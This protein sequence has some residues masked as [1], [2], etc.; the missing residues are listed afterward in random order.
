VKDLVPS[1]STTP[2]SREPTAESASPSPDSPSRFTHSGL[3]AAV[4]PDSPPLIPDSP[5]P[6]P[7]PCKIS[8]CHP[9]RGDLEQTDSRVKD[10]GEPSA[11][12]AALPARDPSAEASILVRKRPRRSRTLRTSSISLEDCPDI[13]NARLFTPR[14]AL[15]LLFQREIR[16]HLAHLNSPA[17]PE[18]DS[19]DT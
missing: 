18:S 5:C 2:G 15:S 8:A 12:R 13:P 9:D 6:A 17:S 3:L 16:R 10:L 7:E 11:P 14:A 19:A 4:S 1:P